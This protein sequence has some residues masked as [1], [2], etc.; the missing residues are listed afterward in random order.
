MRSFLFNMSRKGILRGSPL[1][2]LFGMPV[3]FLFATG[4]FIR[5]MLRPNSLL[6]PLMFRMMKQMSQRKAAQQK[7]PRRDRSREVQAHYTVHE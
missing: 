7:Q 1:K 6:R 5:E 2:L 3:L 4:E